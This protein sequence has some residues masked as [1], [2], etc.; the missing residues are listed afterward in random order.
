MYV[1]L[2]HYLVLE[3]RNLTSARSTQN[4]NN[5]GSRGRK[6]R[7]K[8]GPGMDLGRKMRAC[9]KGRFSFKK[10]ARYKYFLSRSILEIFRYDEREK[11]LFAPFLVF[12]AFYVHIRA[13][14]H[15][16]PCLY[17]H[18]LSVCP[19]VI[20]VNNYCIFF[21]SGKFRLIIGIRERILQ[22]N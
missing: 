11:S 17:S 7:S 4:N 15:A 5:R 21:S 9:E 16:E 12:P 6:N 20:K 19:V 13:N 3:I 8:S 18:P 22:I 2:H 1:F 10:K 14:R